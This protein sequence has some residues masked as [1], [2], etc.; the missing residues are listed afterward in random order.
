[1]PSQIGRFISDAV[2][3]GLLQSWDDHPIGNELACQFI[4]VANGCEAPERTSFKVFY[5]LLYIKAFY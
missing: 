3:D 5:S 1:M 4:D 2:Y